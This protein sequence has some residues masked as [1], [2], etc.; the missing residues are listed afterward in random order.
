M[1]PICRILELSVSKVILSH[2]K[3]LCLVKT[4]FLHKNT[5]RLSMLLLSG[6]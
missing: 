6:Y 4:K 2:E 1:Q 5:M 3:E